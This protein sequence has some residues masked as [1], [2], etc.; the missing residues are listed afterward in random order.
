MATTT[1]K[2]LSK[3]NKK[4]LYE[5]CKILTEQ[6]KQLQLFNNA[7]EEENEG[8]TKKY[9]NLQDKIVEIEQ[10]NKKLDNSWSNSCNQY[11][12]E[13]EKLKEEIKKLKS[14]YP[15][16]QKE[17]IDIAKQYSHKIHNNYICGDKHM[18]FDSNKELK[19][20][21]DNWCAQ[22]ELYIPL[23]QIIIHR[24][25][26]IEQL[27]AQV[28]IHTEKYGGTMVFPSVYYNKKEKCKKLK[29]ENKQLKFKYEVDTK[30]KDIYIEQYLKKIEELEEHLEYFQNKC[31]CQERELLEEEDNV[32]TNFLK[33][34]IVPNWYLPEHLGVKEEEVEDFKEFVRDWATGSWAMDLNDTMEELLDNFRKE[35]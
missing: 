15:K 11:C 17:Y 21:Q 23:I 16:E 34:Y 26:E 32:D 14:L 29:Q 6:N 22:G 9:L 2:C 31:E 30:Q 3:M 10:E 27:K 33:K 18:L 7:L 20:C 24:E 5:H 13:I 12:K 28:G 8:L 25:K 1:T 4:E 35:Q 19:I